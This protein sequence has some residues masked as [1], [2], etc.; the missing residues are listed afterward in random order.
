MTDLIKPN[1]L[2]HVYRPVYRPVYSVH[3]SAYRPS[4]VFSREKYVSPVWTLILNGRHIWNF[5]NSS[6]SNY[7]LG[8]T[9]IR[10]FDQP[11]AS[12]HH[13]TFNHIS[14]L[15][16]YM[17]VRDVAANR[18]ASIR[19][20]SQGTQRAHATFTNIILLLYLTSA[21]EVNFGNRVYCI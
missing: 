21:V 4:V 10:H 13:T 14:Q 6:I 1:Q 5:P 18:H 3:Y 17:S 2:A 8:W 19:P 7:E 11:T 15:E 12:P 16:D 9:A 20:S